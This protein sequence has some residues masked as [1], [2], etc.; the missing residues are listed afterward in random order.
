MIHTACGHSN[1]FQK[2]IF[3][4]IMSYLRL[5]D[6]HAIS[7]TSDQFWQDISDYT[8]RISMLRV[9]HVDVSSQS[10]LRWSL[11]TCESIRTIDFS[12]NSLINFDTIQCLCAVLKECKRTTLETVIL[13]RC[14]RVA[15]REVQTLINSGIPLRRISVI[16]C[17]TGLKSILSAYQKKI[18]LN[19]LPSWYVGRWH[20]VRHESMTGEVHTYYPD[21]TFEFSREEQSSGYVPSFRAVKFGSD[22]VLDVKVTYYFLH[23]WMYSSNN[24]YPTVR[25]VR[26]NDD[27]MSNV[28]SDVLEKAEKGKI[29][30]MSAQINY[31]RRPSQDVMLPLNPRM[32]VE[33]ANYEYWILEAQ[34]LPD[35]KVTLMLRHGSDRRKHSREDRVEWIRI[36]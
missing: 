22:K 7:M 1:R 9:N 33:G 35:D 2:E 5:G 16:G 25:I 21:G 3:D 11:L 10:H 30:M 18:T 20:C 24:T 13:D 8:M 26:L 17:D 36:D 19:R 23:P 32:I 15:E 6:I 34:K 4:I 28:S 14:S 31:G 29:M 27:D 12:D